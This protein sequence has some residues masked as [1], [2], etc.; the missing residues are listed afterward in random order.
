MTWWAMSALAWLSWCWAATSWELFPS[1][2]GFYNYA[3]CAIEDGRVHHFWWCQNTDPHQVV[4][5][6]YYRRYEFEENRWTPRE[7]A[8]APGKPGQWDSLHVCDP[9]VVKGEFHYRGTDYAWLLFYLGTHDAACKHNQIGI[10]LAHDPA[11]PWMRF[12]GNPVV[13]A[14][15][16]TW[17]VG[18]PSV[19]SLDRRSRLLLFYTRQEDDLST[20]TYLSE[21]DLS[22]MDNPTITPPIRVPTDGLA[23][24]PGATGVVLNNAD[25]ALDPAGEIVYMVRPLHP[26]AFAM[27]GKLPGIS[28]HLELARIQ[29][30]DLRAGKGRWER[31]AVIGPQE[32]GFAHNHNA[33]IARDPYG[34]LPN[35]KHLR[36]NLTVAARGPEPLW[37]YT[38][39][40]IV[41]ELH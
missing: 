20:H 14:S 23:E 9:A 16:S 29:A 12:A 11:G 3:P 18:Q 28:S 5:H 33:A 26:N 1:G 13:K 17:G 27:D 21:L 37:S 10:A 39:H 7:L 24:Q 8:L 38:L 35:P 2:E 32:T 4:D 19:V 31:V 40:G 6:I 25:F 30:A 22:Y 36:I 15:A 34:Y 41:L